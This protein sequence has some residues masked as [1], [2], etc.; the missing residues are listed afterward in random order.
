MIGSTVK[1]HI[2]FYSLQKNVHLCFSSW[3]KRHS[4]QPTL[5][6]ANTQHSQ[7]STQPTQQILNTVNTQHSQHSTQ[8]ILKTAN[9]QHS[10]HSTQP[11]QQILNTANTQQSQH[12]T[13]P[14]LS[15]HIII[16]PDTGL[17][18]IKGHRCILEQETLPFS[19]LR[20]RKYFM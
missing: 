12:S 2:M 14:I 17:S 4:T 18:P 16:L 10:Q 20:Y 15:L 6:T 8:Q 7:H 1:V 11:T 9:T 5:N 19:L 3:K 13:Q